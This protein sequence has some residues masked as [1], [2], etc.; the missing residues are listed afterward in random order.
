MSVKLLDVKNSVLKN[1]V[2]YLTSDYKTRELFRSSHNGMDL[3]GKNKGTDYIIAIADGIVKNTGYNSSMGYY[4]E[5]IHNNEYISRYLHMKQGSINVKKNDNV[6]KGDILGYM[7]STG[8]STGAHLHFGV[9]NEKGVFIDPLPYL[10]GTSDFNIDK[11]REFV[12]NVQECIGAKVDGIAGPETLSKTITVSASVNRKH[13]IVKIL[14]DYL[15]YLG[16]TEVGNIDG[17]A[18]PKFTKAVKSYQKDN[19]CVVDGIITKQNKTWKKL[20]KLT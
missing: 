11:Y 5:I 8:D 12:R 17:I 4:C 3:I 20:L 13:K 10:M 14:Q 18:G 19:G 6:K 1:K 15:N 16:Y 9:K 2:H 7:G